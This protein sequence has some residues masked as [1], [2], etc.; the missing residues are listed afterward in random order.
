MNK[1]QY[2]CDLLKGVYLSSSLG[3]WTH[4]CVSSCALYK[5]T[6][7]PSNVVYLITSQGVCFYHQAFRVDVGAILHV[8]K[9][10]GMWA[11]DQWTSESESRSWRTENE[12]SKRSLP[13][14]LLCF[15]EMTGENSSLPHSS[16][17]RPWPQQCTWVDSES[18]IALTVLEIG[19]TL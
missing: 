16:I 6:E 5:I 17:P 11:D 13:A 19:E 3:P 9:L 10:V 1:I 8:R 14:Y 15:L 2:F 12:L 18:S 7:A 4:D